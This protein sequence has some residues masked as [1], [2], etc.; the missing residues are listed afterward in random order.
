VPI[1][2][3]SQTKFFPKVVDAEIEF[4]SGDSGQVTAMML[5]QNGREIKGVKQ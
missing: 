3:E 4:L 2:P 5:H 1:F